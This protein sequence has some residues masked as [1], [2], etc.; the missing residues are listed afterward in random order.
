VLSG[1]FP[2]DVVIRWG[3]PLEPGPPLF[4]EE[5][6]LVLRAV[7][8]RKREFAKGRE[9]ARDAMAALGL[10]DVLLLSGKDR[11]PL[12]PTEIT[13]S[14]TH[15]SGLCAVAV[16]SSSS[17]AGLGIDA[18][19]AE[20]LEPDIAA[21]VCR[22]DDTR[23]WS[24]RVKSLEGSVVE[25]LVFSVKEAVYKCQFPISRMFLGFEDVSTELSEGTF[26]A[27]LRRDAPPFRTGSEFAGRWQ[28]HG[29]HI[30]TGTWL[31]KP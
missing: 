25:R 1:L 22:S 18:E 26:T 31:K 10:R 23:S 3:D 14:I 7:E 6:A 17:Y 20:P 24:R 28:K 5:E 30:I 13:G 4:A 21:R 15:T 2:D 8:K 12:W 29:R 11:E 16:A 19:P 27:T 9:C